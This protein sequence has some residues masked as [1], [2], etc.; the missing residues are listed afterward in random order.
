M[1]SALVQAE[2]ASSL[3]RALQTT[4]EPYRY[5]IPYDRERDEGRLDEP[6]YRLLGLVGLSESDSGLDKGD[7]DCNEISGGHC[8]PGR[9]A[10]RGL[11]KRVSRD[12]MIEWSALGTEVDY[13]YRQWSDASSDEDDNRSRIVRSNGSRLHVSVDAARKHLQDMGL[14]LLIKIELDR[15]K[16]DRYAGFREEETPEARFDRIVVLRRDGT[17]EGVEGPLGTWHPFGP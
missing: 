3:V 6:P 12:G 8:A 7:P 15:R 17:I 5:W 13:C 11:V 16:G 2:T 10:T 1:R 4:E 9:E 14:D